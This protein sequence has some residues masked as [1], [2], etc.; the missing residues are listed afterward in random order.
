MFLVDNIVVVSISIY[1]H[2]I[3]VLIVKGKLEYI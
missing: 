2:Q 1:V 3:K